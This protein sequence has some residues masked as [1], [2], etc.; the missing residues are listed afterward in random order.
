MTALSTDLLLGSMSNT[1]ESSS[2]FQ[3]IPKARSQ[4]NSLSADISLVD[5]ARYDSGMVFKMSRLVDSY[6]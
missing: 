5:P 1:N 4:G 6:L 2:T 3:L